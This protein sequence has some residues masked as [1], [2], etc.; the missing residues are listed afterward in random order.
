MLG[1]NI[2]GGS[3]AVYLNGNYVGA[4]NTPAQYNFNCST[5]G[6]LVIDLIEGQYY[7]VYGTYSGLQSGTYSFYA[8]AN[9]CHTIE[10]VF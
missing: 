3:A 9:T 7:Q 8:A 2:L 6:A 10:L 4:A 1:S 5:Q